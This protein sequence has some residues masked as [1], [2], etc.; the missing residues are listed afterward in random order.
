[1]FI[2]EPTNPE[3]ILIHLHGFASNVKGSKISVLRERSMKGRFSLFA[4][5]M[6]Y[7]S[8][9]TTRVLEVLDA[10]LKG[11]SQKFKEIWLS[12]SSHGGYVSL[13][14]LKFYRPEKVTKVF[15]LA[16]SYSTLSLILQEVGEEK[17]RR[18]LEGK[19]ELRFTECET[20]L[21]LTISR[22]FATDIS[23]KGYEIISEGKVLFPQEV[24]QEIYVFHGLQDR[25][26]PIEHSR[27][28]TNHVRV[29]T[30]VE[31]EDDHK[32]SLTFP[33]LVEEFM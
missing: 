11:F 17:C 3:L 28:F 33:S 12:G 1:M 26:V 18:W 24:P 29:K 19:E 4:M 16:P 20:G 31:L 6:E 22:D 21:E 23:A 32:L 10:L 27:L 9:N 5:D 8:T 30:F 14:Y 15:L 13:N 25:T 7:Q 2:Y